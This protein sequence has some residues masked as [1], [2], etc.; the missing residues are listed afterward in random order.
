[1]LASPLRIDLIVEQKVVVDN[2]AKSDITPIDKQQYG[3]DEQRQS[4]AGQKLADDL[5]EHLLDHLYV[6]RDGR[7]EV[8][9]P[10]VRKEAEWQLA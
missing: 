5:G 8:T 6:F 10:P 1:M 3:A 4:E 2:K 7:V 9:D